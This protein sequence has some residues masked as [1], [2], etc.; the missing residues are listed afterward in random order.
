MA[1]QP[2]PMFYVAVGVVVLGL[3][4]FA[5]YHSDIFR[6]GRRGANRLS[7][8]KS[9]RRNWARPRPS[10]MT[11]NVASPT[12]VKEYTLRS[13]TKRFPP[14]K[15]TA[16]YKAMENNTVRFALNVW[17]GWAPIIYANNGFAPEQSLEDSRRQRIPRRAGPDRQP[18]RHAGRVYQRPG[19]HRLGHA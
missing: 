4:G 8:E 6:P 2:K 13:R 5:I 9:T 16:A 17:A 10:K 14:V 3:V 7:K 1:G 15:G 19:S 11:A 12:T 18:G